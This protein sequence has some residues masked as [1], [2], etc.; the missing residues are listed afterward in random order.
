MLRILFRNL[1]TPIVAIIAVLVV[2]L[3]ILGQHTDA[4]FL[5]STITLNCAAGVIQEWRASQALRRLELLRA[6]FAR[7]ISLQGISQIPIDDI[8]IGDH[9]RVESGDLVPADGIVLNSDGYLANE[10]LLTGESHEIS[11]LEGSQLIAG[12]LAVSGWAEIR[13]TAVGSQTQAGGIAGK[14]HTYIQRQTP[15]QRSLAQIVQYLTYTAIIISTVILFDGHQDGQPLINT[16][17]TIVAG[18]IAIVPEGLI[19]ASTV[20]FSIGAI[21]LARAGVLTQRLAAVE[22]LSRLQ[23]LCLD[24]TGTLTSNRLQV[25]EI[26]PSSP[27]TLT[28]F[29]RMLVV[30]A[31]SEHT[32]SATM[33]A[34]L[35]KV[36]STKLTASKSIPFSSSR[37]WSAVALTVEA[38]GTE[39]YLVMGAP[40]VLNR[41]CE[42]PPAMQELITQRSKQGKRTL[43]VIEVFLSNPKAFNAQ[44]I[45]SH[46]STAVGVVILSQQLRPGIQD[47]LFYLQAQGVKLKIISGDAAQ[48]VQHIA[49]QAGVLHTANVLTGDQLALLSASEWDA[50]VENTS[51]FARILPDQ[52]ERLVA[53]FSSHGFTGMVGDGVNDALALKRADIG[54]AMADGSQ[55]ARQ[56]AD[57]VLLGNDFSVFPEGVRLGNQLILGLQLVT[58]CYANRI[59]A[60][61]SL[62]IASIIFNLPYP[63]L[64]NHVVLV[65]VVT[66]A[67]PSLLWS[68]FPPATRLQKNPKAFLREALRFSLPNGII[69]GLTV[70][71]VFTGLL[72]AGTNLAVA[73]TVAVGV[74]LALGTVAFTILPKALAAIDTTTLRRWQAGYLLLL[75]LLLV[76]SFQF[77][78]FLHFFHLTHAPISAWVLGI[79]GVVIGAGIQILA[80]PNTHPDLA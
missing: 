28:D 35:A 61:L 79:V 44:N 73:R 50:A 25:E 23:T 55:A 27:Y 53:T 22:G 11:K 57:I 48:T 59:I 56:V 15:L 52:K 75:P 74:L 4:L 39:R 30:L 31:S 8:R 80:L 66:V 10:A 6:P 47:T 65:N 54:I 5:A 21:K 69:T 43:V 76:G 20:L 51:I 17:N 70:S 40:D 33:R 64:P 12:S 58:A 60:G 38:R 62:L 3:N 18:A 42:F 36:P 26:R 29:R 37:K 24:K 45:L 78:G 2:T 49:H 68:L 46:P 9:L 14:L 19:L 16:I 32:P 13:I 1:F 41:Y 71:A 34:V 7:R 77:A 63:V 72:Q 67:I